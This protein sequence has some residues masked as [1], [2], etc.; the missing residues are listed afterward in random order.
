M[1]IRDRPASVRTRAG[2]STAEFRID[3]VSPGEAVVVSAG[4]GSEVVQATLSVTPDGSK[5]LRVPGRQFAKPG[6]ELRFQVSAAEDVYKRQS[7][8][9]VPSS[10]TVTSNAT[11]ATFSGTT[12]AIHSDSTAIVTATYNSFSVST[13]VI[14]AAVVV[15][16]AN[17]TLFCTPSTLGPNASATCT[18]TLPQAAPSSGCLLYTSRCV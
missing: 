14:L 8:L 7:I 15:G 16:L 4:V 2:Q 11:T 5:P 17:P 9:T 12:T 1:C 3:A 10:V 13:S 18:V 6:T